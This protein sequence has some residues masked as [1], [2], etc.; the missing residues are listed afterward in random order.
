MS[1]EY[2]G[3]VWLPD[4]DLNHDKQIQSLL[5]YRYTIGQYGRRKSNRFGSSVKPHWVFHAGVGT[6]GPLLFPPGF[7]VRW[8][9][10]AATPLFRTHTGLEQKAVSPLR[11]A[12][13]LQGVLL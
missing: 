7:G 6:R 12:T 11:S 1:A 4:M 2:Q 5:C 10:E 13:A 8:Q 9:S 3:E